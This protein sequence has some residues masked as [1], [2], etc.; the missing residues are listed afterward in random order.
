MSLTDLWY[1]RVYFEGLYYLSPLA[2]IPYGIPTACGTPGGE[3]SRKPDRASGAPPVL[4]TN[5]LR[6]PEGLCAVET[7][8]AGAAGG[9]VDSLF[10][11]PIPLGW[12]TQPAVAEIGGGHDDQ[13]PPHPPLSNADGRDGL[14]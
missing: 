8:T 11:R 12:G 10:W 13:P 4:G 5:R 9:G 14:P 7:A 2:F 1:I 3:E 6:I